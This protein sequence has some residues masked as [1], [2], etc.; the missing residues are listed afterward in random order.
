M[1]AISA[2]LVK[3]LR[4]MTGAGIMDCKH[5][6]TETN[7]DMKKAVDVLR[8]KGIAKAAKKSS[9][10]AAEGLTEIK[11][12]GNKAVA[13]EVNSETDFV[14]KNEQFRELIDTIADHLLSEEPADVATALGQKLSGSNETVS[15][16]IT[17]A[18]AKIGEK[19]SLR[20]FTVLNKND[21]EHFGAYLHMGGRIS[22]LVKISGGDDEVAKDVAMHVAAIKP[23]YLSEKDIPEDVVNHEKEVLK[24][25]ALSEGKP[26][27]I[28]EKM[29]VGRLKKFFKE[30][31]LVD[32]SFVKDGDITVAQ[33]LKDHHA[34]VG[35]FVRYEVGEG[36]EKK[37]ENFADEVKAQMKQ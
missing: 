24:K 25:E 32:Q 12:S 33:Y 7:G 28:V 37:E 30:I 22:A 18:I 26:A 34:A 27:N 9:R 4:D 21:D 31:C 15:D 6:L 16:R 20:R 3:E 11:V 29:I 1:A 13:L 36:I 19:I 10:I 8:E 35:A 17:A 5:A 14:A 23:R 2:K